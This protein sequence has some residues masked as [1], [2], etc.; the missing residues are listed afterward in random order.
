MKNKK[1][2]IKLQSPF[3]KIKQNTKDPIERLYRAVIMQM[4]IDSS[5]K[6]DKK[7][8]V[9][10]EESAKNWLFKDNENFE[11]TCA[12]ANIEK[13]LVRKIAKQ[14]IDRDY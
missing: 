2:V 14:I 7:E 13:R 6:S 11:W 10:N 5:N 4:I 1:G 9:K 8:L 12:N 3:E